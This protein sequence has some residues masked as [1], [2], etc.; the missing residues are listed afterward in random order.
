[1]KRL[2][3]LFLASLCALSI[4]AKEFTIGK[5]T[6]KTISAT[7]VELDDAKDDLTSAH[8]NSTITYQ[9]KTYRITSIGW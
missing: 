4:W 8:L 9:G 1:M 6:Y 3:T 5:L 7:E 2:L